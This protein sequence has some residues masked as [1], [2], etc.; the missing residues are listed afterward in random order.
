MICLFVFIVFVIV[1]WYLI[2]YW[3]LKID[4]ERVKVIMVNVIVDV[5]LFMKFLIDLFIYVWRFFK[6]REVVKVIFI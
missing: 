4:E 2:L 6:F 1:M 3:I 5:I